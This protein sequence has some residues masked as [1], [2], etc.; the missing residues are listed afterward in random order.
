M[1]LGHGLIM[2]LGVWGVVT[3][4]LVCL[5]VYRATLEQHEDGNIFLDAAEHR[6][7][8]DQR[9]LVTRIEKLRTPINSLMI[10]SGVLLVAAL[11]LW[12]FQGLKNF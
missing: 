11:G 1:E 7:A 3:V 6:M 2:L 12:L 4:A 10:V 9:V 8:N 5:W